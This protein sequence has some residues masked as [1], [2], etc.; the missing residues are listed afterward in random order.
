LFDKIS[1]IVGI[2]FPSGVIERNLFFVLMPAAQE[3]A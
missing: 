1:G 2:A 3:V